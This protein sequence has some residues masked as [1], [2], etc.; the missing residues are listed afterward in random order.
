MT[1]HYTVLRP[2]NLR[3]AIVDGNGN[4]VAVIPVAADAIGP[5]TT[6]FG[7]DDGVGNPLPDGTYELTFGEASWPFVIDNTPPQVVLTIGPTRLLAQV[8]NHTGVI[9]K[10]VLGNDLFAAVRDVNLEDWSYEERSA[11]FPDWLV[12]VVGNSEL[13]RDTDRAWQTVGA[14]TLVRRELRL[15][16]R[17]LAGNEASTA[18]THRDEKLRFAESEPGCRSALPPCIYPDRPAVADLVDNAGRL[19][20]PN[21]ILDPHYDTM[22]LQS[23]VWTANL[24]PVLEYRPVSLTGLPAGPWQSRQHRDPPDHRG[25]AGCAPKRPPPRI[26]PPSATSW[27]TAWWRSTGTIP[28]WRSP[29]S[30]CASRR[31]TKTARPSTARSST[32]RRRCRSSSSTSA[33]SPTATT[34]GSPTSRI[35]RSATSRSPSARQ[36]PSGAVTWETLMTPGGTLRPREFLNLAT[37]CNLLPSATSR[38]GSRAPTAW[39]R[40]RCRWPSWCPS[41]RATRCSRAASSRPPAAR[42]P[43]RAF[44]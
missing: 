3:F 17:D 36:A 15:T 42:A 24:V 13:D 9:T 44:R 7:G 33:P 21:H 34:C 35:R 32:T 31:S 6:T 22:L 12:V 11:S 38:S 29:R 8:P 28:A 14:N 40:T 37:L 43:A 20:L 2:S 26:R 25:R 16:A 41:A 39:A 19:E 30:R 4:E 23:T 5:R 10:D 18:R 27:P 1:F